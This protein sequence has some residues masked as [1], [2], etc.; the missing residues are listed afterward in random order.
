MNALAQINAPV[1]LPA[2]RPLPHNVE[3]EQALLGAGFLNNEAID[4][5]ARIVSGTDLYDPLHAKIW[6]A[7]LTMREAGVVVNP[8]TLKSSLGPDQDLGGV[9]VSQ[10]LVRLAAEATTVANAPDYARLIKAMADRRRIITAATGAIESAYEGPA[11][12]DPATIASGA[13]TELDAI[14]N[15]AAPERVKAVSM[16]EASRSAL[17]RAEAIADKKMKAYDYSWGLKPLND[18]TVGLAAGDLV[19]IGARPSMGKTTLGLALTLESAKQGE[20]SCFFSLEMTAQQLAE[21]A[22]AWRSYGRI[23]PAV[24]YQDIRSGT[25]KG[26]REVL[27]AADEYLATLPI[28]VEQE[29]GL[30]L[31][32]IA[33][34]ARRLMQRSER[35]GK[36]LTKIVIDHLGLIRMADRYKGQRVNEVSE[37]TAGMKALAKELGIPIIALCQLSRATEAR[38]DKRPTLGDFRDS[39]SIEQDAD[40]VMGLYRADYY[41]SRKANLTP[42]EIEEQMRVQNVMEAILLKQRQGST[43]PVSLFASMPCNYISELQQ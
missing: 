20:P 16:A 2:A 22:L 23:Q 33:T 12:L 6:A 24:T 11:T 13:I 21:R 26:A 38:D 40:I 3:A 5:A 31:A 35:A 10:Y 28:V 34:R 19:I 1:A 27:H 17:E 4:I 42:E 37:V 14:A 30:T 9:T 32:Q 7:M 39:G 29:P 41:L 18:K 43:G 25:I 15:A 8:I 36:R